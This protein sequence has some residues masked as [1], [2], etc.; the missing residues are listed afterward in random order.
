MHTRQ[1][2][3]ILASPIATLIACLIAQPDAEAQTT[4][5]WNL[6]AGGGWG[7]AANWTPTGPANGVDN[8]ADFSTQ[9]ITAAATLT[10]DANR[11]IGTVR[12]GDATNAT[13]DWTLNAGSTLTLDNTTGPGV[14]T[15]VNRTATIAA[16]IAGNDGFLKD[17]VGTLRLNAANTWTG[18][19]SM[20]AGVLQ[21][22]NN[23][24]I[25][26]LANTI[27][28]NN[29]GT[30]AGGNGTTLSILDNITLAA[31]KTVN[32][33]SGPSNNRVTL[34]GQNNAVFQGN[35]VLSGSSLTQLLSNAGTFTVSGNITGTSAQLLVRGAG[36]GVITGNI[37]I[38]TT[39]AKTDG[40]TWILNTTG[41]T[42]TGFTV[43]ADGVLQLGINNA[44][45]TTLPVSIG[46]GSA[47]N[48]RF[49]LNGFNQTIAALRTDPTSSGTAHVIRNSNRTTPSTLNFTTAHRHDRILKNLQ[50]AARLK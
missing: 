30:S 5:V 10:L 15:V 40:G 41:H 22:G 12:F 47:T 36:T 32:L 16:V 38:G 1:R 29:T 42:W 23:A 3:R 14:I 6:A 20:T 35:T 43:I 21:L 50:L 7:T 2:T 18:P 27:D 37:N 25:S 34:L 48:G 39:F 28:V 26:T 33:N 45:P 19:I 8:I 9:D 17:G 4:Y 46:Q 31:T 24:A 49:E 44:L 11:T 13:H